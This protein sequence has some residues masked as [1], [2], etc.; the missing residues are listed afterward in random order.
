[1]STSD[2]L[3]GKGKKWPSPPPYRLLTQP[4][5][6][7]CLDLPS[8]VPVVPHCWAQ[9]PSGR[10]WNRLSCVALGH[11]PFPP[12]MPNWS[13]ALCSHSQIMVLWAWLILLASPSWFPETLPHHK[14]VW[15][16]SRWKLDLVYLRTFERRNAQKMNLHLSGELALMWWLRV[17]FRQIKYLQRLFQ[18]LSIMGSK[19]WR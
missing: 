16:P 11:G 18:W 5:T 8:Q 2:A 10:I 13:I 9:A 15:A 3:S 6:G 12:C 19:R 7:D 17:Y 1:M 4:P 14:G